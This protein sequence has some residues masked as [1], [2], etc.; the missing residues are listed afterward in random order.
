MRSAPLEQLPRG[1]H[2]LGKEQVAA[3]QSARLM[4]AM[5]ELMAERG[6]GAT[7]VGELASRAGVSRGAFYEHFGSKEAC[8]I[9]AYDDWSVGLVEA[10]IGEVSPET[11]WDRFIDVTLDGYLDTL[12]A[13]PVAARAFMVEM[14]AAG[15]AARRR[16]RE[17]IHGFAA[18][19]ADRHAAMRR[20]DPSLGPL[21]ERAYLGFAL[22]V[23]ELIREL[24]ERE[25][26]EELRSLAPDIR[27]WVTAMVAGA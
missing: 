26:P 10:M 16:R 9:A 25:P 24:L 15:P 13:D 6:S 2:R 12:A 21:P 17:T 19:L 27:A 23:R 20:R 5:V 4:R 18:L 8:L 3:S 22:G 7:T 11:S 1:P 14:D